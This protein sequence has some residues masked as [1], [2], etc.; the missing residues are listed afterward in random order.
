MG[1]IDMDM[2]AASQN[3]TILM[4]LYNGAAHLQE[5]LDS[6]TAQDHLHWDLLVSDDGS[7]DSGPE[8]V[9]RYPG[10][11]KQHAI[12]LIE[13]PSQGSARNFLHLIEQAPP[14][15]IAFSDQDD[16]WHPDKLSRAMRAISTAS[17]PAIYS[18]RTTICD[19]NLRPLKGARRFEGPF[20]FRNALV[21]CA[22][23]G[24]TIVLN[25]EGAALL[26]RAA[27]AA[28]RADIPAHDWWAY[29]IITGAGGQVLRDDAE[30]LLYR[31]HSANLMGRNDTPLAAA[32]R[33]QKLFAREFG[34]WL[35][36]NIIALDGARD[37][38]TEESRKLLDEFSAALAK[39]GPLAAMRLRQLGIHRQTRTGTAALM[40]AAA[41]GRL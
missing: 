38:L 22:T 2:V 14:G 21:Q 4:A 11:G 29:Q 20:G 39:S 37:L 3:V 8:I 25:A 19:E 23:A 24:N 41:A 5:Q 30:V 15:P 12:R 27:P 6:F 13:G 1:R 17:G 34:G 26:R 9:A 35:R 33:L 18:A 7:R 32:V 40:A 31:Q 10:A 28:A 36:R 16:L